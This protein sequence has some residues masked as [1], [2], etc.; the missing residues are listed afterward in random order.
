MRVVQAK[1][2]PNKDLI[3]KSD[4]FVVVFIRPLRNRTK[5]TRTIVSV[6]DL[7]FLLFIRAFVLISANNDNISSEQPIESNME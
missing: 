6:F 4:P 3:G 1:G 7:P 5:R 2:L